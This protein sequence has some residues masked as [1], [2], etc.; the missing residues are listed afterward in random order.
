M[1]IHKRRAPKKVQIQVIDLNSQ[2]PILSQVFLILKNGKANTVFQARNLGFV[3]T[4]FS[5]PPHPN[6]HQFL[7]PLYLTSIST[8]N[9]RGQAIIT[10]CPD[11]AKAKQLM[12]PRPLGSWSELCCFYSLILCPCPLLH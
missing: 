9:T 7:R 5:I 11:S 4:P 1:D 2:E 6:H 12:S 8:T 10:S 3:L